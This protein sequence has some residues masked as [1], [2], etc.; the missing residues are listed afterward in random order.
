MD[1]SIMHHTNFLN[2]KVLVLNKLFIA[3]HVI[4]VRRAFALLS[5]ESAEVISVD[6]GQFNSYNFESW[7]DVSEYKLSQ[8]SKV[9]GNWIK[10][11]SFAIEA[12][13]IVRLLFYDKFPKMRVKFNRKNIFARDDNTCQYCGKCFPSSELSLE[14]V[15]PKSRGGKNDWT[16]IVCACTKCNKR[17]GNKTLKEAGLSLTRPPVKPKYNPVFNLK[18][19]HERASSW[20]HFIDNAYWS[21]AL[22]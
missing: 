18:L 6:D 9:E 15:V 12:P 11:F 14:H 8:S 17:K 4:T 16:N 10:T 3:L 22:K 13:Q 5:K 20:E 2:S 21:T 19:T 1:L 7:R